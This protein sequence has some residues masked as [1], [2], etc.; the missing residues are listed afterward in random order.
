[1]ARRCPALRPPEY[2]IGTAGIPRLSSPF[3]SLCSLPH[4]EKA[5]A[6]FRFNW[7]RPLSLLISLYFFS[8]TKGG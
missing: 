6:S 1:M 8:F 2:C 3:I 4:A 7:H 5:H